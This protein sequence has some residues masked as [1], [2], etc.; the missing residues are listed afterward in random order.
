MLE[1]QLVKTAL[2]FEYSLAL[3][4]EVL[5]SLPV[6]AITRRALFL[7]L[8]PVALAPVIVAITVPVAVA[9]VVPV[10]ITVSVPVTVPV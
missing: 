7:F 4:V 8:P 3:L 5:P 6:L 1:A 9:I 2:L 10:A